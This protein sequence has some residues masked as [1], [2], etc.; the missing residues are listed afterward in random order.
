MLSLIRG[1][2]RQKGGKKGEERWKGGRGEK[3]GKSIWPGQIMSSALKT[4]KE[5]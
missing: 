4:T 1:E 5:L 2:V 3:G